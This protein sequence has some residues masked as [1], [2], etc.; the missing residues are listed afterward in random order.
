MKNCR[1][2]KTGFSLKGLL[3]VLLCTLFVFFFLLVP[4][5]TN[6]L[7]DAEHGPRMIANGMGI[8][9][10]V[11][12]VIMME[13]Q[14]TAYDTP[15]PLSKLN[16]E[17]PDLQFE[18]NT[19]YFVYLVTNDIISVNWSYF[20]GQEV[21]PAQGRYDKDNPESI[22]LFQPENNAWNVV[23]DLTVDDAGTPFLISRNVQETQLSNAFGVD[24]APKLNGTPY[25]KK[26]V[27]VIRMG[28]AGEAMRK[29][30]ILWKNLNPAKADNLIL[31]P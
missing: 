19:D 31:Q 3:A 14:A 15:L 16:P 2:L 23:A 13:N 24:D 22:S 20:S 10:S 1:H 7:E 6:A 30:N 26:A 18:N 8:Y 17:Y 28:G 29:R 4:A 9:K 12:S 27:V 25:G 5:V 11:F 21:P